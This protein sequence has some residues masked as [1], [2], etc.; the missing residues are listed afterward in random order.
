MT[1]RWRNETSSAILCHLFMVTWCKL[2]MPYLTQRYNNSWR[3]LP[4]D[5][6]SFDVAELPAMWCSSWLSVWPLYCS[7]LHNILPIGRRFCWVVEVLQLIPP[8]P[9]PSSEAQ[10]L[11]LLILNWYSNFKYYKPN[12]DIL[13]TVSA[14]HVGLRLLQAGTVL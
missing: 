5:T 11:N 4:N 9:S 8:H 2:L 1:A 3:H 6:E 12:E 10:Q 13:F 7:C 14:Q